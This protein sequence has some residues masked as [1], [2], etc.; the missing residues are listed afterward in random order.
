M[1]KQ[2]QQDNLL[3][4]P[5]SGDIL[6]AKR[7]D[8]A[9]SGNNN[10]KKSGII[11]FKMSYCQKLIIPKNGKLTNITEYYN[12]TKIDLSKGSLEIKIKFKL[13]KNG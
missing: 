2:V 1:L 9:E 4:S 12:G 3:I 5:D 10:S 7:R 13:N 11:R 8:K 6:E